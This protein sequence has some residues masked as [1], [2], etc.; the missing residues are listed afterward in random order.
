MPT[1]GTVPP[2][3]GDTVLLDWGTAEPISYT[4]LAADITAK[5]VDFTV[6]EATIRSQGYG[7]ANVTAQIVTASGAESALASVDV[8]FAFDLPL[9]IPGSPT[10][11]GYG[12]VLNGGGAAGTTGAVNNQYNAVGGTVVSVGDLNRDGLDDVLVADSINFKT[13]VVYGQTG[14]TKVELSTLDAGSNTQGFAISSPGYVG[15]LYYNSASTD[16]NGDG[17][18]DVML[19]MAKSATNPDGSGNRVFVVYGRT[20]GSVVD[21]SKIEGGTAVSQGLMVIDAN[22]GAGMGNNN[23]TYAGSTDVRPRFGGA[24]LPSNIGLFDAGDVNGDGIN[25]FIVGESWA[26]TDTTN[27]RAFVM[28][29]TTGTNTPNVVLPHM[30]SNPASMS[31][32][33][34]INGDGPQTMGS[35]GGGGDVNGDGLA[36]LVVAGTFGKVGGSAYVVFGKANGSTLSV[37]GLTAA[38]GTNGFKITDAVQGLE[39]LGVDQTPKIQMLGDVNGDGLDD[40]SVT[41]YDRAVVVFGKADGS[42]VSVS[43]IAAGTSSEGF[44]VKGSS[45][46]DGYM[47]FLSNVGDVNGDGLDDL[48]VNSSQGRSYL[49]FG[50][51]GNT[52]VDLTIPDLNKFVPIANQINPKGTVQSA[53][54]QAMITAAGDVN[55]DGFADLLVGVPKSDPSGANT[56][57]EGRSYV[58]FGGFSEVSSLVMNKLDVIG[59]ASENNNF[60]TTTGWV[61][62]ATGGAT[63]WGAINSY[64]QVV[65]DGDS[66]NTLSLGN[67]WS[68]IGT[69]ENSGKVYKVLQSATGR[70]QVIVYNDVQVQMAP[71]VL[72][73]ANELAGS[74]NLAE[75][76]S[77]G[78]TPVA[79]SLADTGAVAGNTLQLNWGG[80]TISYTLTAADIAAG[81]ANVPVPTA[82]LTTVTAIGSAANVDVG[83]TLLD[84]S[85]AVSAS[86]VVPVPVNF[87]TGSAPTINSLTWAATG[88]GNTSALTGIPEAYYDKHATPFASI[89]ASTGVSPDNKLYYSEASDP[90]DS[91]TIMRVQL[92]TA[93]TAGATSP[94]LAGDKL[95]MT[96]GDQTLAE[97][98]ITAADITAKYVDVVVPFATIDSQAFGNVVVGVTLTSAV[99]GNSVQAPSLTVD[100]SYDLAM[101]TTASGFNINGRAAS[102]QSGLSAQGAGVINVGDVNGDGYD[103]FSLSDNL[104]TMYVVYGRPGLANVE[105]SSLQAVGNSNGYIINGMQVSYVTTSGDVNGDG[106]NDIAINYANPATPSYVYFGKTS[107]MGS[108]HLSN[109][110][111]TDGL[112]FSG[113]KFIQSINV[114][115]DMNGDGYDDVMLKEGGGNG[116]GTSNTYVIYGGST[117]GNIDLPTISTGSWS[118]GFIIN[119]PTGSDVGIASKIPPLQ[120]DFN[121]DGYGDVA[122]SMR[123]AATNGVNVYFGGP[124]LSGMT[125]TALS[126]AGNDSGS[127][128]RT[129]VAFGKTSDAPINVSSLIAGSGGFFINSIFRISDV[130]VVGD[131]NGDGLADMLISS[132][133]S[134][135]NSLTTG[136]AFLVYGRT[137]TTAMHL[138]ALA[139]SEGFRINGYSDLG[140]TGQSVTAGGDINGDGFADLVITSPKS[141]PINPARADAGVTRVVFGG[142][143]MIN[144][145]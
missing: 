78:G 15:R 103:D 87:I 41:Q 60:N 9:A 79:I 84:G 28:F 117:N 129:F 30:S 43:A 69:V 142:P 128:T 110:K 54:G 64:A 13:Y 123:S 5:F 50:Q 121:G 19:T 68:N 90:A 126:A 65:V 44:V 12:Y 42:S 108:V 100:W 80:Q 2:K 71:S 39:T 136:S 88:A 40:V 120:G 85:T 101:T 47:G 130:D 95:T 21:V 49:V 53:M 70:A 82:T 62:S 141:D 112:S 105:L 92:P 57:T 61:A 106:L 139:A 26:N 67:S 14:N 135:V 89:T 137:G 144:N 35:V 111:A 7:M 63:N 115:G 6:P 116:Y 118:G 74:L 77:N 37:S 138:S 96:W 31:N 127:S 52:A 102:D 8:N 114:I 18:N 56:V 119:T 11:P 36:D 97:Y 143:S 32:G 113:Q 122:V 17:L 72:S 124:A 22:S 75:A 132:N 51:T 16:F 73:T 45:A 81:T 24:G 145:M 140:G 94:A 23:Y 99:S 1:T 29:G 91:G 58:V 133:V 104:Q 83:V 25:D 34:F 131:F 125:T 59:L 76:N 4:L 27:G 3:A 20:D 33:F 107:S 134:T 10:A 109:F 48:A 46:L 98:T 86:D 55:G 66:T 38:A 93:G